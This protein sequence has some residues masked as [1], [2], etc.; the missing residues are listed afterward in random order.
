MN[1]YIEKLIN[2][3][4]EITNASEADATK[5]LAGVTI[6]GIAISWFILGS[7]ITN[8]K[9]PKVSPE[10]QKEMLEIQN[11]MQQQENQGQEN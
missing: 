3:I 5:I 6:L 7:F 9:N 2:K 11:M 8:S 10:E 4:R 1:N